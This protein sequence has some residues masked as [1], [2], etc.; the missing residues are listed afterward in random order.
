MQ[1]ATLPRSRGPISFS[2][3]IGRLL[4]R[5]VHHP[6]ERRKTTLPRGESSEETYSDL[7]I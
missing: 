4:S 5:I 3:T 7:A 2:R 6:G 1:I